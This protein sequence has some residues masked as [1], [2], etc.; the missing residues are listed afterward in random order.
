[1]RRRFDVA[2]LLLPNEGSTTA[3]KRFVTNE[4]TGEVTMS[5]EKINLNTA[6]REELSRIPN[7]GDD[8]ASRILDEREKRGGFSSIE[9]LGNL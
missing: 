6:S 4:G 1:L 7:I 3:A 5:T 9:E 8:C 2:T